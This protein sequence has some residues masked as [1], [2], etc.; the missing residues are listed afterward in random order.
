MEREDESFGREMRALIVTVEQ[1]VYCQCSQH[2]GFREIF[3]KKT[4]MFFKPFLHGVLFCEWLCVQR[5]DR[6]RLVVVFV[7][8]ALGSCADRRRATH[9]WITVVRNT[10][11]DKQVFKHR[12]S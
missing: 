10:S 4:E 8:T 5:Q 2:R 7:V 9:Y 12:Q 1:V 6:D 3:K 11:T